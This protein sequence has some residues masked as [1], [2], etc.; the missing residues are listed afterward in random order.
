MSPNVI[1]G[2]KERNLWRYAGKICNYS[3]IVKISTWYISTCSNFLLTEKL[4]ITN[5][6]DMIEIK[7][8]CC[9]QTIQHITI[10][11]NCYELVE[12]FML[13]A[14]Q[15]HYILKYWILLHYQGMQKIIF[16]YVMIIKDLEFGHLLFQTIDLWCL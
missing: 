7:Q 11:S 4:S 14:N 8:N 16:L 10:S 1:V 15:C 3:F 2:K 6:V 13:G 5:I 9:N 12:W